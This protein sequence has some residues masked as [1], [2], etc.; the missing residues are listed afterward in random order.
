MGGV[1]PVVKLS[2]LCLWEQMLVSVGPFVLKCV[3]ETVVFDSYI[4]SFEFF[5]ISPPVH[6]YA[7]ERLRKEGF[8]EIQ[9]EN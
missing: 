9:R 7:R 6:T 3:N 2:S 1:D 5:D 8:L 4:S